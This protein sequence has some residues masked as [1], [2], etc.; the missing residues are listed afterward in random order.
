MGEQQTHRR[1]VS[2]ANKALHEAQKVQEKR[3]RDLERDFFAMTCHEVRNPLNGVVGHLRLASTVLE[4][5]SDDAA[6][7][8]D[9]LLRI[10]HELRQIIPDATVC[11]D[12][13]LHVMANMT[14][15][16]RLEA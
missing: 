11:S 5:S 7:T 1:L 9:D 10:V 13:F 16:Q 3:E 15:L 2:A 14:S 4:A 12:A 8:R 6:R